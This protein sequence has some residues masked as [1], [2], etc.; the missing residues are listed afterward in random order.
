[1]YS[2][3]KCF[4]VHTFISQSP[5][6]KLFTTHHARCMVVFF[7]VVLI[8]TYLVSTPAPIVTRNSSQN[9]EVYTSQLASLFST[10]YAL[11]I[12]CVHD[13]LRTVRSITP[14]LLARPHRFPISRREALILH[15]I[16]M[17][18][19]RA[20]AT[21]RAHRPTRRDSYGEDFTEGMSV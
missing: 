19:R 9:A 4:H 17:H 16:H 14:A 12:L 2:K 21:T 11:G 6:P 10:S 8:T 5:H 13:L 7:N 3:V 1:M 15:I 20:R 18:P